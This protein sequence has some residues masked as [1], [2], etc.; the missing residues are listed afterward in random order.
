MSGERAPSKQ[1]RYI[2]ADKQCPNLSPLLQVPDIADSHHFDGIGYI[3]HPAS[4]GLSWPRGLERGGGG[5][6]WWKCG[7]RVSDVDAR[8]SKRSGEGSQTRERSERAWFDPKFGTIIIP[9]PLPIDLMRH[10]SR[11]GSCS[12]HPRSRCIHRYLH[13]RRSMSGELDR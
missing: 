13:E 12:Y 1:F 2:V 9:F 4:G 3:R 11:L 6:Q 8:R 5:G 10:P 7:F